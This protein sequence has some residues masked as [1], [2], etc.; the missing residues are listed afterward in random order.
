MTPDQDRNNSQ[1]EPRNNGF[2]VP[3]DSDSGD[4]SEDED[5]ISILKSMKALRSGAGESYP[6]IV[7]ESAEYDESPAQPATKTCTG[8]LVID[9]DQ[10][11]PN[12]DPYVVDLTGGSS[13]HGVPVSKGQDVGA[14]STIDLTRGSSDR[15]PPIADC[16]ELRADSILDLAV[17]ELPIVAGCHDMLAAPQVVSNHTAAQNLSI[18]QPSSGEIHYPVNVDAEVQDDSDPCLSDGDNHDPVSGTIAWGEDSSSE[19]SREATPESISSDA[20]LADPPEADGSDDESQWGFEASQ[21]G[22]DSEDGPSS[23]ASAAK[24]LAPTQGMVLEGGYYI[25]CGETSAP[26]DSFSNS[27]GNFEERPDQVLVG[28]EAHN[29]Q[30]MR[31]TIPMTAYSNLSYRI[32]CVSPTDDGLQ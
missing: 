31:D 6:R 3:D 26:A 5:D 4:S 11:V 21:A 20:M 23:P 8:P 15:G 17:Q 9:V 13:G 28:Q 24:N 29:P 7:A 27:N 18:P 25:G 32:V 16:K 22:S 10:Y 12:I 19:S 2:S 30:G 1:P 14:S